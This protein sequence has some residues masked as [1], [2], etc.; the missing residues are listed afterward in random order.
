MPRKYLWIQP[1]KSPIGRLRT[2][3]VASME[4]SS[5]QRLITIYLWEYQPDFFLQACNSEKKT[6]WRERIQSRTTCTRKR[7]KRC[8]GALER[9]WGVRRSTAP[10]FG[11]GICHCRRGALV[12]SMRCVQGSHPTKVLSNW[13]ETYY[14]WKDLSD[15]YFTCCSI[16]LA[17]KQS[18]S[19]LHQTSS[20]W[21]TVWSKVLSPIWCSWWDHR[22]QRGK[23]F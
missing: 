9:R 15:F 3:Q 12:E 11:R 23:L 6:I 18:A 14:T 16:S 19:F 20:F 17:R 2:E 22:R 7:R 21:M 10:R 4:C 5:F 13:R 8:R 1:W